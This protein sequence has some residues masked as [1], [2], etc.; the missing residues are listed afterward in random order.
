M[1]RIVLSTMGSLGDLHPMIALGLELRRRGHSALINSWSGYR[2]KV[3][4]LG[5]EFAS[6]RP[7]VDIDDRELHARAMDASK[8]PEF[9]IKELILPNIQAMYDDVMAATD[10]ADVLINGEIVYVGDAVAQTRDIKWISSGL[11]PLAMFSSHDPNVYPQASWVFDFLRPLPVAFHDALFGL[12]RWTI[13][14][15]FEPYQKFRKELGLSEDHDPVFIDKFSP[16]LHLAMFSR[17]LGEPQPDWPKQTVQTGAC[18]F[19][20]SETCE[21][22]PE[23]AAFL[24][25]GEPPIVFTLGS[26]AVLDARDFFDESVAAARS[27]GKRAVVLYGRDCPRPKGLS[28]EIVGFEYAPFSQLF[29]RSSCV[30]HQAGVGTTHQVLRA[31]VPAVIVP[32]SHDQPDNAARCRR[33]GAAVIVSRNSY[34]RRTAAEAIKQILSEPR[35]RENAS[36]LASIVAQENG[37]STACD[38]VENVLNTDR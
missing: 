38:A 34:N 29:P 13:R 31:G 3:E 14:D 18:F 11:A 15:W 36:R 6:L 12:M 19:D 1:A 7:D 4:S 21:L 2:E 26:A 16:L 8:G 23:L 25:S 22:S 9:V 32:F 33:Q 24:D 35:Y 28:D 30:V 27:L 10:G 17:A 20:E 37:I 5:L